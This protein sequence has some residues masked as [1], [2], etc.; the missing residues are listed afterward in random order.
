MNTFENL[1]ENG[2]DKHTAISMLDSYASKIGTM[3]GVYKITDIT[4][5]FKERGRDVELEC[6]LCGKKIHRI[7]INGRNK[8]SELIK[9]CPCQKEKK[10]Q[11]QM[12]I[13]ENLKIQKRSMI[14]SRI[15]DIYGDYT[16]I[17]VEDIY[18]RNPRYVMKCNECGFE[19][20]VSA[21]CFEKLD[22]KCHKHFNPIKYD[23][24]YIGRKYNYL[25]IIGFDYDSNNHRMAKCRCDCGNVKL[26]VATNVVD[27]TVKSCGCMTSKLLHDAFWKEDALNRQRLYRIW[28]GM[29]Q[30]C[31][32]RNSDNYPDY[33]GRGIIICDEWLSS[34]DAFKEW[35][36]SHGYS[37]E[38]SIDRINVNGNYEPN[39]CRWADWETQANNKR[40]K[41]RNVKWT[42]DGI[43]KPARDWCNECGVSY[44]M[45]MYR[46]NHMGMSV[47]E[48]LTT[49]KITKGRNRKACNA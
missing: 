44:E 5:D 8:W 20:I 21:N 24:S 41:K 36:L 45:A 26:I 2:I 46:I 12:S 17:S 28:G 31:Y 42:I 22:F 1:I 27:G 47:Y 6:T 49:P 37:D 7:M 32:N 38:L 29:K 35:A 18:K 43:T 16:I 25:E 23:D 14:E 13:S 19:K 39:N 34:Y 11:E 9:T 10:L 4:Y 3:N 30:R 40:P 15:G 48:A 33:G